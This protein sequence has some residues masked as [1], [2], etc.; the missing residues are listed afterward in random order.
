M[1]FL[2]NNSF[3]SVTPTVT[4]KYAIYLPLRQPCSSFLYGTSPGTSAQR[5][6]ALFLYTPFDIRLF[7]L[8]RSLR[9]QVGGI[10]FSG[11]R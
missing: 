10:I 7:F 4:T 6:A 11:P 1:I 3:S 2:G 9:A 8:P 5:Q